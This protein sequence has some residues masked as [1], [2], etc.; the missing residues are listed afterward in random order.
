MKKSRNFINLI[1]LVVVIL[2]MLACGG[3]T[4]VP[5]TEIP[6]PTSTPQATKT[7]TRRPTSTPRPTS[8]KVPPTPTAAPVGVPVSNGSYEVTVVKT[9]KLESVYLSE[10]QYWAANPGYQFMELGVRVKNLDPNKAASVRWN[11][12]YVIEKEGSYYPGWGAFQAVDKGV[13]INP[14]GLVFYEIT[15]PAK[16]LVFK[17]DAFLRL[18]FTIKLYDKTTFLFGFGDSPLIEIVIK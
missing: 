5:A 6:A 4:F 13:E 7:A 3:G 12:V 11:K 2:F 8:T 14:S 17:E 1:V 10:T 16:E 15:N 18:I 9:R